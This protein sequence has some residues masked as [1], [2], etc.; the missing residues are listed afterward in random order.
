MKLRIATDDRIYEG[1]LAEIEEQLDAE[2]NTPWY[3]PV[4]EALLK[5]KGITWAWHGSEATN[6]MLEAAMNQLFQVRDWER[7]ARIE[8]TRDGIKAIMEF[9]K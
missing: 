8:I 7:I 1:T 2:Q 4:R 5:S 9:T 6:A 3:I